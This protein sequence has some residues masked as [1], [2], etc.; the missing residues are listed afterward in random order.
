MFSYSHEVLNSLNYAPNAVFLK[1]M[2]LQ[3]PK[4][5]KKNFSSRLKKII[6][7]KTS[8]LMHKFNFTE[9]KLYQKYKSKYDLKVRPIALGIGCIC[10]IIKILLS[11]YQ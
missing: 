4:Y 11:K 5:N 10:M 3:Q 8:S 9:V 7:L 1:A 2:L 6:W